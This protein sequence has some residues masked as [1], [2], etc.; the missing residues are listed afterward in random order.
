[1]SIIK[2][3]ERII[4]AL[5][6]HQ[7]AEAKRLVEQLD[8]LVSFFKVGMLLYLTGGMQ[9]VQWL[10]KRGLKVFLDLKLYDVPDTVGP[11]VRAA[12]A[13]GVQMLTV[14]GNRDILQ[15][16]GEA[17]AGTGLNVL[18]VTVLTSLDQNDLAELGYPVAVAD[19]VLNRAR[20]AVESGCAGVIASPREAGRLRSELGRD[21]LLVTPGIR[22]AGFAVGTHKRAATPGQAIRDGA[23]YLV[24]GQPIIKS[25]EPLRVVEAI[26]GEIK[27][28]DECNPDQ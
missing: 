24:I 5:D 25:A 20:W 22:P 10:Q 2:A 23:D 19:L 6:V 13:A 11:A 4:C 26:I 9:F 1:M 12:A 28:A 3:E 7:A 14:H 27:A 16:A 15:R 17:A 8:G 21:P 18:A